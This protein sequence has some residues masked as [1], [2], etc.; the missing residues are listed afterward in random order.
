MV[1]H[2][3]HQPACI[4]RRSHAGPCRESEGLII[5]LEGTGQHNPVRGKEPCFVHATKERRIEGLQEC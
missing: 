5:P 1:T 2:E 4:R 3:E